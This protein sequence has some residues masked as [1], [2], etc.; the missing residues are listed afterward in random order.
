MTG[1]A[2]SAGTLAGTLEWLHAKRTRA[3]AAARDAAYARPKSNR[4]LERLERMTP[5]GAGI[6]ATLIILAGSASLGVVKGGHLQEITEALRDTRDALAKSAGFRI[7]AVTISG[8]KQLTQDE[9][10]AIGGV[11]G[12]RSL[13]FLDAA[14]VRDRLKAN[15]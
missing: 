12:R 10:L 14:D 5:R 1:G 15:P 13:L 11:T 6:A 7:T 4:W 9:V 3:P 2:R 8:R